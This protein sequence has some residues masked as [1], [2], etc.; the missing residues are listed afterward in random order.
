MKINAVYTGGTSWTRGHWCQMS[1]VNNKKR[2]GSSSN[3]IWL[4][5]RKNIHSWTMKKWKSPTYGFLDT[6]YPSKK[7]MRRRPSRFD[8]TF[9]NLHWRK[10]LSY[11]RIFLAEKESNFAWPDPLSTHLFLLPIS[12][13]NNNHKLKCRSFV[14]VWFS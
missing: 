7:W 1:I 8:K 2:V 4:C 9:Q 14:F 6:L 3:F 5:G 10:Q 12:N 11:E 13:R